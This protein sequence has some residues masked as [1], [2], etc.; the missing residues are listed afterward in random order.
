[1][2]SRIAAHFANAGV[3]TLLLDIVLPGQ[4]DR[5]AAAR[6]GIQSAL[7]QRPV[8]FFAPSAAALVSPGNLEDDLPGVREC[9]WIIEAVTENL[10]IKRSLWKR[11]EALRS[12]ESIVSTNTS[13]IPLAKICEGFSSGFRRHFLGTHFF[14]PPRYLHLVEL[15]P[16]VE[17]APEIL[18]FICDFCDR[19]LGKGVVPCKDTPNF[20]A[21]RIGSFFVG[22]ACKIMREGDYSIEEVDA[23]TGP[24]IGL[25]NSATLR[26]LDIIGLDIWSS[27]GRNLYD[28]V[29]DDS[30]RERFIP[31]DYQIG[32]VE[33]GSL[34]EKSGQGFYKRVGKGKARQIQAI[35]WKTLEYHPA[36]KA[37]SPS[38]DAARGIPDLRERLRVLVSSSDRA[39]SFLWKLLSDHIVY[40]AERVPEISDRIVEIDRAMRWGYAHSLGPFEVWDALGFVET[41]KRI[42]K[43]GRVLPPS[44]QMMLRTGAKSF[45]RSGDTGGVPRT[46][47]F[48]FGAD[49]YQVLEERPGIVELAPLKRARGVI[50]TNPSSSLIDLGDGV[51]C[52]EFHSRT[53]LL[54]EEHFETVRAGLEE[55]KKNF[56]AVVIANQGDVFSAGL[57]L[58]PVLA[59][60]QSGKWSELEE[61]SRRIQET[62]FAV[63]H[64]ARPVVAAPFSRTV[65]PAC[66]IS[67]HAF[68]IQ[69]SAELTMGFQDATAGLIPFGGGTKELLLRTGAEQALD[70]VLSGRLSASALDA[71]EM[72]LLRAQD[73]TSM[74]PERLVG[75]ARE[76]ALSLAQD[77]QAP[78]VQDE[79]FVAGDG[80]EALLAGWM[81]RPPEGLT[82]HDELIAHKLAFVLSGGSLTGRKAVSERNLLDLEREAFL[83]LCGSA[84]TQ[85]R[86]QAVLGGK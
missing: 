41:A 49:E 61:V 15:I 10:E 54:S 28:A 7:K 73:R 43:E 39:G 52:V 44:V 48:D 47:Y 38:V 36:V 70:L 19:R 22:T 21:N 23:L 5:N 56:R 4:E 34:G 25:P 78:P 24:L 40:A 45:Y 77:Y 57:D 9:D 31:P 17:T 82:E 79:I 65:G 63:K 12:A 33:R 71:R 53:N 62:C 35:D 86:I 68:V 55:A 69:A 29:P 13:G 81:G 11:V 14:N 3:P 20:I 8:G 51:L 37:S 83:S 16:G 30:W 76:L 42:E 6:N 85:E 2:G 32:M 72:G 64:A 18:A 58:A 50:K 67:L 60:A 84:A 27:M 66:E 1:M 26:L 59:A 74:N 75:D 80:G 46:E